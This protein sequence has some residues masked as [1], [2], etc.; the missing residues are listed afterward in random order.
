MCK[1][2][3]KCSL[4]QLRTLNIYL[5]VVLGISCRGHF[6]FFITIQILIYPFWGNIWFTESFVSQSIPKNSDIGAEGLRVEF[7]R[8]CSTERRHDQLTIMDANSRI[9]SVRSGKSVC[10]SV[11]L[12]VHPA[13]Q[14]IDLSYMLYIY[15]ICINFVYMNIQLYL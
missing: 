15:Y 10:L 13:V 14:Y 3:L 1:P 8:Q 9:I 2:R 6:D 7:H 5:C 12:F 4:G 11:C